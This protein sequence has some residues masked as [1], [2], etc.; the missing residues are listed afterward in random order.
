MQR[1]LKYSI[2]EHTNQVVELITSLGLGRVHLLTHDYGD[3]I[4]QELLA[5]VQEKSLAFEIDSVC[6]LNGGVFGA[7]YKPLMIQKVLRVP[8]LGDLIAMASIE[9]LFEMNMNNIAYMPHSYHEIA[10]LWTLIRLEKGHRLW[11]RILAYIDERLVHEHRWGHALR[12]S[13]VPLHFIYGSHDPINP[14]E[15]YDHYL[16]VVNNPSID[17]FHDLGH[18]PQLEDPLRVA[19]SYLT[20]LERFLFIQDVPHSS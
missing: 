2:V 8:Y 9:K 5:R 7:I 10:D 19:T 16:K 12:E 3:S 4:G 11:P 20:F 14:I 1:D 17:V 13:P 15:F 6:M 18:Y